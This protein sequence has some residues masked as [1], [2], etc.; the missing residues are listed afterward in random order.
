MVTRAEDVVINVDELSEL[1]VLKTFTTV[2]GD[3]DSDS[4]DEEEEK[5]RDAM[6]VDIRRQSLFNGSMGDLGLIWS[7]VRVRGTPNSDTWPVSLQ[8]SVPKKEGGY[9]L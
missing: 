7:I 2:R 4:E 3:D 5:K 8:S 1:D 9:N 6:M